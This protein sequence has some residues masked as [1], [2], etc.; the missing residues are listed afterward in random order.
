MNRILD[1]LYQK[2]LKKLGQAAVLV[3]VVADR[4][5]VALGAGD[6]AQALAICTELDEAA[7]AMK[8]LSAE[9]RAALAP[10]A[11]GVSRLSGLEGGEIAKALENLADEVEDVATGHDEDDAVPS[12]L[13][14]EKAITNPAIRDES[15]IGRPPIEVE[16]PTPME[17]PNQ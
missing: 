9:V 14:G 4:L 13:T 16:N 1:K 2:F 7:D 11:D 5:K 17:Y 12:G 15:P 10:D 3:P 8:E 6:T